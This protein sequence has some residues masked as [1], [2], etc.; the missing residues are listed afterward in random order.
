MRSKILSF[1]F[2]RRFDWWIFF[3]ALFLTFFSLL[4]LY[5]LTFLGVMNKLAFYKQVGFVVFGVGL[6]FFFSNLNYNAWRVYN[7]YLYALG[8][9]SLVAVLLFG[10]VINNT[11]GWFFIGGFGLQPVEFVKLALIVSLSAYL[12]RRINL[13]SY[14]RLFMESAVLTLAF[15]ALVM[16]QPD[17]GSAAILIVIWLGMLLLSG[18]PWRYILLI[19][20][21]LIAI[22]LLAWMFFL[23]DYQ[24]DRMLVLWD[25]ALDPLGAGYNINQS[26]IAIGSGSWLG[27]GLGLGSQS[28]LKF[29]PERM[30]DFILAVIGEEF[31]FVGFALLLVLWGIIFWR[32]ISLA[33]RAPNNFAYLLVVGVAIVFFFHVLINV[34]MNLG[35]MPVIGISL[36][37]LS[38][39]GSFLLMCFVFLG[40]TENIY[41]K[42]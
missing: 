34:G 27:Q 33:Q 21:S 23:S 42:I 22:S 19:G 9:I 36:P 38:Q 39:G 37:F 31:G 15:V 41:M 3:A 8:I 30:T 29:I 28:Q 20:G 18:F 16:L 40:M 2:N 6:L 10:S 26:M 17:L 32:L 25:P 7:R 4:A 14:G 12:S 13:V 35:V 5:S 11:K 1:F 24:K